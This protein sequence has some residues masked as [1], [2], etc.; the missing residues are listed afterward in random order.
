MIVN[1]QQCAIELR[2]HYSYRE[3]ASMVH[4]DKQSLGRLARGEMEE[5]KFSHG[6]A[7]LDL[8]TDLCGADRTRRLRGVD[9]DR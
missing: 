6:V 8:H 1:W 5:P 2:R 7:L 9:A 4:I 3:L